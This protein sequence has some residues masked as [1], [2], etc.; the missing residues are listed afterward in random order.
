MALI[1]IIVPVYNVEEYID[2][3]INSILNQ[4]FSDFEL[5]LVNDG[6]KD[7]CGDICDEF[8]KKDNRIKVIHK[9]NGGLSDAR[10]AGIDLAKGDYIG[11]VDSDDYIENDMYEVLYNN[12]LNYDADISICEDYICFQKYEI[13]KSERE[14]LYVLNT[15]EAIGMAHKISPGVCNKLFKR[16]IFEGIKFPKGRLNEDVFIFMDIL[17]KAKNI[18][19]TTIPKYYYMQRQSS[20]TKATFD[21]RKWDCVEAWYK[22]L[23]F[24]REKY[25]KQ[26]K[27]IEY[28]YIGSYFHL[29]DQLILLDNYKNMEDYKKVNLFIKH[30]IKK[31]IL[32]PYILN[33]RKLAILVYVFNSQAY[34]KIVERLR[35][36]RGLAV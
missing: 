22:N 2:K 28:K 33:K 30:N 11:F 34:R 23:E 26:V 5:I 13:K 10:N 16:E 6:S 24:V 31:I 32:N 29:L 15:E 21:K 3:C 7:N 14:E 12:I 8:S 36:S 20:I 18:I 27:S 4:T 9:K 35:K 25:P 19:F 17:S 1:S